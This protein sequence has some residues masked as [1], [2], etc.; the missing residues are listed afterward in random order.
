MKK[1]I[2]DTHLTQAVLKKCH[3]QVHNIKGKEK[4]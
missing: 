4:L 1:I 3:K 2:T